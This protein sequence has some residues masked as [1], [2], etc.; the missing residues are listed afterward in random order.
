VPGVGYVKY[1]RDP[2]N[3]RW[4]SEDQAGHGESAWKVYNKSGEWIADADAYG[5]YMEGKH[6]GDTGKNLNFNSMK[7]KGAK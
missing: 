6:K 3:K 5:D 4:W 2:D 1:Y 7:C